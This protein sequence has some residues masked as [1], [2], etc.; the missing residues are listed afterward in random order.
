QANISRPPVAVPGLPAVTQQS[1]SVVSALTRPLTLTL[2]QTSDYAALLAAA[3]YQKLRTD[4]FPGATTR[5]LLDR[6]LRHGL[7][8][9]YSCA[10]RRLGPRVF[11]PL[12]GDETEPEL[13]DIRPQATVT[14]WR[15]LVARMIHTDPVITIGEFL[16]SSAN[17]QDPSAVDLA[18]MRD[19]LRGLS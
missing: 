5:T 8:L 3:P 17:E 11:P 12:P 13:V 6:L 9:E 1:A 2:A 10:A 18:S 15:R 7:L 4:D 19:A 14:I 16:D